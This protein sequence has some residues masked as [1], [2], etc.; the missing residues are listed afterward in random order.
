MH[1]VDADMWR[2]ICKELVNCQHVEVLMT[3]NYLD[4]NADSTS[5]GSRLVLYL[6]DVTEDI[7]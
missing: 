7:I 1:H 3:L 4:L 6:T 5:V 2:L